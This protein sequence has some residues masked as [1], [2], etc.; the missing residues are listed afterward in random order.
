MS[1]TDRPSASTEAH[2]P[3]AHAS[4]ACRH[5]T[6]DPRMNRTRF[7][8]FTT[9]WLIGALLVAFVGMTFPS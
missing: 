6:G 5:P 7:A 2:W 4:I 9:H 3:A 1:H 8:G